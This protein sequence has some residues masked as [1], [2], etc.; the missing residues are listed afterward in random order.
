MKKGEAKKAKE[1]QTETLKNKQE[2]PFLGGKTRFFG[3]RSTEKKENNR[4]NKEGLGPSEVAL[5]ASSPDPTTKRKKQ[6]TTKCQKMSFL[7]ISQNVVFFLG[8]WSNISLFD[9]L[10]KNAGTQKALQTGFHQGIF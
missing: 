8:G 10:A 1:K 2:C 5:R 6:E 4:T 9:N 7:V 3:I